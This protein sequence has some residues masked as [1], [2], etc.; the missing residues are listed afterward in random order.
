MAASSHRSDAGRHAATP[1]EAAV[2]VKAR[3][4]ELGFSAVGVASARG[5]I[6]PDFARYRSAIDAGLHG[7]IDYLAHNVEARSRL[8]ASSILEGARSVVVVAVRYDRPDDESDPPVARAIARYARGRDYHN[9][10]RKKLRSLARA[11]KALGDGVEARPVSDTAPIL[12][13]AWAARA[14]VGFFAKNG[15]VIAPGE[16]SFVLL[17]EVVTTLEIS[18]DDP[19]EERCGR[20]TLCLDAC[21]TRALVR[22]F[23]LDANKCVATMTIEL[24]GAVPLDL[25]EAT[26]EHLFGCDICQDVCPH[27][28]KR[29][30]PP[31]LDDR[32]RP[33]ARWAEVTMEELAR[34]GLPGALDFESVAE[35]SPVKR[36]GAEGLARN[37]CLFLGRERRR[38]ALG[39]LHEIVEQH[40]SEVVR[41][42]A[43]WAIGRIEA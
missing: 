38:A 1:E 18:P 35:G 29:R 7:P 41:D 42:A 5:A 43:R 14:G 15:L 6:E 17:G 11:V 2:I 31:P 36:A 10:L 19:I 24:R 20:C 23:V 21:P 12:E 30:A 13:K 26:G 22:P 25:R 28:Q 33:H 39:T 27:N 34:I 9:H 3:G 8:D 4:R 40:P 37:A 32:Y 16:G